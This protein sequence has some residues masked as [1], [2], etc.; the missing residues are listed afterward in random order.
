MNSCAV[1]FGYLGLNSR[2]SETSEEQGVFP[3]ELANSANS[4]TSVSDKHNEN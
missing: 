3:K 4:C 1:S 2:H